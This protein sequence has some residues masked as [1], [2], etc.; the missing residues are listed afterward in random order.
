MSFDELYRGLRAEG[1]VIYGAQEQLAPG[2]FRLSTMGR[3]TTQDVDRF[4]AALSG[5]MHDDRMR[6]R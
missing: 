5:L 2:W 1:F 3:M 4:L 6:H